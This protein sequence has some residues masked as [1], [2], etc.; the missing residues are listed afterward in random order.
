[1]DL[2]TA[3]HPEL[4]QQICTELREPCATAP[5]TTVAPS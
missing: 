4:Q 3:I 5:A 1:M 2:I